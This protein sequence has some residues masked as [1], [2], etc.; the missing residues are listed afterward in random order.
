MISSASWRSPVTK[1]RA[2]NRR[3]CSVA[4]KS[5]N[6]GDDS[7]TS[8]SMAFA[9]EDP[10]GRSI[11]VHGQTGGSVRYSA[12]ENQHLVRRRRS[13]AAVSG[14]T[15]SPFRRGAR[16]DR[17]ETERLRDARRRSIQSLRSRGSNHMAPFGP[18]ARRCG[19]RVARRGASARDANTAGSRRPRRTSGAGRAGWSGR[20]P[21]QE[22]CSPRVCE[23]ARAGA[24]LVIRR[25]ATPAVRRRLQARTWA[26][27]AALCLLIL[28][29]TQEVRGPS[30]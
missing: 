20:C 2:A 7:A 14:S 10:S 8:V 18:S 29:H 12:Y 5:S 15:S 11:M 23:I 27:R 3:A 28:L 24:S 26:S 6:R 22:R 13:R 30:V 21:S 4:K 19:T 25:L 16:R 17:R 1:H 9:P